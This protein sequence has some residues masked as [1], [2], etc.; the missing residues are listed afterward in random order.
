MA[1]LHSK[2]L[3]AHRPIFF[4]FSCSFPIWLY[5]P[6]TMGSTWKSL[7]DCATGSGNRTLK[8]AQRRARR[9]LKNI[10][11]KICVACRICWRHCATK[12]SGLHQLLCLDREYC[13]MSPSGRLILF[14]NLYVRLSVTLYSD[15]LLRV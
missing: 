6:D 12:R 10:H 2:I 5:L 4:A 11:T 9:S 13:N 7:P 8:D 15:W 1:D 14:V 3:Y